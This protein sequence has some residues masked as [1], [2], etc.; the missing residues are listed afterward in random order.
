MLIEYVRQNGRA[1]GVVVAVEKGATGWSKCCKRDVF[2]KERGLQI[3]RGRAL[4][5]SNTK[6]PT[7]II[8]YLNKMQ[9]RAMRYYK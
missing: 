6:P 9:D 4:A 7:I 2:N 3:A 5:G 8:P 1:V